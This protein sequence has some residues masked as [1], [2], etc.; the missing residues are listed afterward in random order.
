MPD[1]CTGA[2]KFYAASPNDRRL[3]FEREQLDAARVVMRGRAGLAFQG[4]TAA[5]SG[6]ILFTDPVRGGSRGRNQDGA[7]F[8]A[9]DEDAA[10]LGLEHDMGIG[11]RLA[12]IRT[13]SIVSRLGGKPSHVLRG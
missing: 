5:G 10:E 8:R 1:A 13:W 4:V 3:E 11:R 9:V 2:S 12:T 6:E 7:V